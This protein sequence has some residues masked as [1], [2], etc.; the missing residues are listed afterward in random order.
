MSDFWLYNPL[1][2]FD[3]DEILEFWPNKNMT[4]TRKM[5]AIARTI[6]ALTLVGF[7]FTQ[8]VKLLITSIITLVVLVVLYKTQY[9]KSQLESLKE[10]A[11]RENFEGRN[12]DKFVD[13][14]TDT[15][16]TPTKKNPMMNV[17]MTDYTDNPQRKMA[18]PSYNKRIAE[19]INDK[20]IKRNKLYQDLG[21]NLAF[22]HQMRNFHSMPNTT[23]P[24]NQKGFAEFCYGTMQSCK[25]GD[26]EQCN[27]ALRKIGQNFY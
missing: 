17:L 12:A 4:L 2:L 11:Y 16:T 13:V 14:F 9:E 1:V 26:T 8:S 5:N 23:I 18:A 15:F 10:N 27:K 24:N 22:E 19:K 20:S 25:D 21:D 7:L 6:I 3:K